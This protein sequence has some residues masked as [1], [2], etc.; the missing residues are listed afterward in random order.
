MTYL[1]GR[2]SRVSTPGLTP[3]EPLFFTGGCFCKKLTYTIRLT[4]L[5]EAR[6]MICH[7][8]DCKKTF[9][10]AF[11]VTVKVPITGVRM[12]GGKVLVRSLLCLPAS[13]RTQC[14]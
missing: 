1:N 12:T 10:S 7:C 2:D 4:S 11:G 3:T 13:W 5:D 6:T 9:G 14:G 8:R